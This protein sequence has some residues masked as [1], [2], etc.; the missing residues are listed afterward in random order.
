MV[1]RDLGTLDVDVET[2]S[3]I[4]ELE[5]SHFLD[6]KAKEITPAKLGVHATAFGNAA[7]GEI[8]VGVDEVDRTQRVWRGFE[9]I[10]DANAHLQT[11]FDIFQGNDVLSVQFLRGVGAPGYVLH[12]VIEKSREILTNPD[13]SIYIRV[14]AQRLPVKLSSHGEVERLRLDKG[15]S[16]YEDMPMSDLDSEVVSDS[17]TV[18]R[19]MIDAVPVSEPGPWLRSQRLIS[20][21]KPTVAAVLLFADEPQVAL[22]KRSAIKIL[23]YKSSEVEGKRDQM[24]GVP[25][26]V[27]GPLIDQIEEAVAQV[28]K[29]VERNKVQTASGLVR[30]SYPP[31]TLHE[32]LTNAVLHR[33]YSIAADV[34]VRVFDNRIEVESPGRL[35]GHVTEENVLEEQFARNGKI[36]RLI[37][38]FPN[39]PNKDVGE[40]LNTAYQKMRE[41]GLRPPEISDL[42]NK[43][44]V[45]IRHERL[46]SHEE[47]ILEYLEAHGEINN[48]KARELTGEG[49]ENRMKRTFERMM[50][51]R[52]I[53]RD[54]SRRGSATAYLLGPR[55]E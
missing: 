26:T 18:T 16:S 31:E 7:G 47:Q 15:L 29:I 39:P 51:A 53:H 21:S 20:D 30:V 19:F 49:S 9:S 40:G 10:E 42:E 23:R 24:D 3:K 4:L 41:I 36:V 11:L 8:Y 1:I 32:I 6:L 13:G 37:N 12:L 34:Q 33:D 2:I 52:Q 14:S 48:S 27:E 5:E 46:A 28:T 22:P 38:K 55:E 17:L 45:Y 54:P 35:P 50:K 44:I 43:V 25:I